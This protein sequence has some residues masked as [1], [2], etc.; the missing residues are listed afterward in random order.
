MQITT[1]TT[2]Y[3]RDGEFFF[4]ASGFIEHLSNGKRMLTM[5][6]A[7]SKNHDEFEQRSN[8]I[9]YQITKQQQQ[10]PLLN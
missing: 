8:R 9:S 7:C 10:P 6:S 3:L 2:T 1:T 4:L 5:P